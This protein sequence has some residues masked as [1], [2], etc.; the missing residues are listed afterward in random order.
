MELHSPGSHPPAGATASSTLLVATAAAAAPRGEGEGAA[1]SG[2]GG[3]SWAGAGA[4]VGVDLSRRVGL[5]L[6]GSVAS[7]GGVSLAVRCGLQGWDTG[8]VVF[9]FV[10]FF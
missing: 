4:C 1:E 9:V 10:L 7:W 6:P 3:V 2:G 8:M 5:S